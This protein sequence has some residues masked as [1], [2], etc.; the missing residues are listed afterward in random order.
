[1][2]N[3]LASTAL[4][5]FAEAI[6]REGREVAPGVWEL[7]LQGLLWRCEKGDFARFFRVL[8]VGLRPG[9]NA[10]RKKKCP[11]RS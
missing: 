11:M 5:D 3:P 7:G 9:K 10:K 2:Q 1:M 4:E 8:P 6:R